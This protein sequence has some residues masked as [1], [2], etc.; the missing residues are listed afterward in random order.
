MK[1]IDLSSSST[2]SVELKHPVTGKRI[3]VVISGYTP[4]SQEW[5][6]AEARIVQRKKQ[7]LIMEK[8]QQRIELDSDA[9]EKRRALLAA[10][11]TGITGID[12][13]KFSHAAVTELFADPLYNW[14]FEQWAEH[15][16]DRAN[17]FEE[18]VMDADNG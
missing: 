9:A 2:T 3:G 15:L 4:D 7:S 10:V 11:V 12:D 5:K 16:D 8:G 14:M 17:F 6:Q 1:L 18:S 13:W